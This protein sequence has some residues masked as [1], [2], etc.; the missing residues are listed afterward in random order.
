VIEL[1]SHSSL[2]VGS[3]PRRTRPIGDTELISETETTDNIE[4][5]LFSLGGTDTMGIEEVADR[6]PSSRRGVMWTKK[7]ESRDQ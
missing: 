7:D 1:Y 2:Q 4:V 5:P 6:S 3:G